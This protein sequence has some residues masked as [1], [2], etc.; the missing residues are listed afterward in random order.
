MKEYFLGQLGSCSRG[1]P[2]YPPGAKTLVH[3]TYAISYEKRRRRAQLKLYSH[4]HY[5]SFPQKCYLCKE[6]YI[7]TAM[8]RLLE[9]QH[10]DHEKNPSAKGHI[11]FHTNWAVCEMCGWPLWMYNFLIEEIENMEKIGCAECCFGDSLD[12]CD[13]PN[14]TYYEGKIA[15]ELLYANHRN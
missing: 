12:C 9:R 11:Y 2:P 4:K 1:V 5:S 7:P 6:N 14:F 15:K 3:T 13:C 8:V 10:E